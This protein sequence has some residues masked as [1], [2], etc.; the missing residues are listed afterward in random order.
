MG[1]LG[2][3]DVG[4][5]FGVTAQTINYW[6]K[7]YGLPT[8]PPKPSLGNRK[9]DT[10]RNFFAQID[11]PA[12][13]YIL[14]FVVADGSVHKSGKSVSIA[15]KESDAA[16]LEAIAREFNYDGPIGRKVTR[17]G[18]GDVDRTLAV[19]HL[20]GRKLVEDLGVLGVRANKSH[21]ATFPVVLP[22]LEPHLVRGLFDG[23]GWIGDQQFSLVGTDEV[24]EG[25]MDA[26]MRHTGQ[27]L[28]P[29]RD[30]KGFL[31]AQG[32]RRNRAVMDWMY[33]EAPIVLARKAEAYRLH[34]A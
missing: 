22:H 26:V 28:R 7:H 3:I 31:Y 15:I 25:T 4:K 10:N 14:G 27:C 8:P 19:L 6:R 13:A 16:L 21:N 33:R 18:Y 29:Y 12:K 30:A 34:W 32:A 11:T 17:H 5:I 9:Y 20:C 24:V 1:H 2:S 23:D